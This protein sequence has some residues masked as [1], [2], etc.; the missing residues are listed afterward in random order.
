MLAAKLVGGSMDYHKLPWQSSAMVIWLPEGEAPDAAKHFN[1]EA[2]LRPPNPNP[3]AWW[4][5]GQAVINVRIAD[6]S[7]T[8]L[9]W[10]KVGDVL[11]SPDE[12]LGAYEFFKI[13]GH[14]DA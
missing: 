14:G 4:D 8:K 10:I 11:L 2:D 12:V 13:H 1:V 9:P 6:R 3:E 7:H 5:L